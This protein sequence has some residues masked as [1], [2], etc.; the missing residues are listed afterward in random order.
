MN[1]I[2]QHSELCV[3]FKS[4]GETKTMVTEVLTGSFPQDN[5]IGE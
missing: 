2:L 3:P 1:N 4:S 5:T